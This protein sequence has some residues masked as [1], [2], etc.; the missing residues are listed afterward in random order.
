MSAR[1]QKQT[2]EIK[3]KNHEETEIYERG[4]KSAR[5]KFLRVWWVM[6]TNQNQHLKD[7]PDDNECPKSAHN[8][9]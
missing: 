5:I 7:Y 1:E 2:E 8:L 6:S 9:D 4:P 3:N